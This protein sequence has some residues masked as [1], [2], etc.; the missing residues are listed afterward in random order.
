MVLFK[1]VY[2]ILRVNYCTIFLLFD[3]ALIF[4]INTEPKFCYDRHGAYNA[5]FLIYSNCTWK[6]KIIVEIRAE[7]FASK[8]VELVNNFFPGNTFKN[9][10]GSPVVFVDLAS[11]FLD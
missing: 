9:Y 7:P 8:F 1:V 4:V 2:N 5:L 11:H 6:I 3:C 10:I